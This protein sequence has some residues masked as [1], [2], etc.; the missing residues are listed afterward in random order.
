MAVLAGAMLL[1]SGCEEQELDSRRR[2]R[3]VGD[4]NLRLKKQLELR[5]RE[6]KKLEEV[7]AEYEKEE[8]K[9]ADVEEEAGNLSLKLFKDV[10]VAA[11]ET[12][13]LSA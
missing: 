1:F 10:A 7:I 4:E 5:N 3:L 2:I 12:E 8:Q 6:I 13:E 9:R 11:K